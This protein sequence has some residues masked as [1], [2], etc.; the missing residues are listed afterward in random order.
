MSITV[1]SLNAQLFAAFAEIPFPRFGLRATRAMDDWISD[2]T[3]LVEI[4][5]TQDFHGEWWEISEEELKTYAL[6]AM[7][8]LEPAGVEFYLPAYLLRA[9]NNLDYRSYSSIV[10]WLNPPQKREDETEDEFQE[11]YNLFC[12][13]LSKIVGRKRQVCKS[14][15]VFLV[16]KISCYEIN[17]YCKETMLKE[18]QQILTHSYWQ[19]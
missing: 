2:E 6:D 18:I 12:H 8:Y 14:V 5:A 16:E 19:D 9:V 11:M 1:E 7:C 10:N 3:I 15:L 17:S 4:T 13:R